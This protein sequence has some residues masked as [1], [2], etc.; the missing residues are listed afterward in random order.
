M[1]MDSCGFHRL[2]ETRLSTREPVLRCRTSDQRQDDRRGR[3]RSWPLQRT[4]RISVAGQNAA[5]RGNVLLEG[6]ATAGGEVG[7]GA[8]FAVHKCLFKTHVARVLK[9]G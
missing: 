3:R 6:I 1:L 5:Q 2:S 7:K 4:T 9:L 8:R